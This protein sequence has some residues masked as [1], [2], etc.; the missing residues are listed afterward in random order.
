[1]EGGHEEMETNITTQHDDQSMQ[2]KNDKV[3]EDRSEPYFD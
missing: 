2:I 3:M 1:M